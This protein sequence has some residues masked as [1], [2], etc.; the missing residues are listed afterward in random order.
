MTK[1]NYLVTKASDLPMVI[2]EA[3]HIAKTGRPGPVLIDVPR[4]VLQEMTTFN[5]Y[6][7]TIDLPG[8]KPVLEPNIDQIKYAVS[9]INKAKR[10]IIL[11]GRGVQISQAEQE[12]VALA[13]KAQIPV[14]CTLLG[15]GA[16]P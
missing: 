4:D 7:K 15:L 9:L 5:E 1:H 6:P 10:P 2:K 8:Y 11:A 16:F 12:L 3:F 13:E 14:I